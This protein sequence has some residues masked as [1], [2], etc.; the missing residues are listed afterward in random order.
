MVEDPP[1][2]PVTTP[3]FDPIVAIVGALLLHVPPAKS[4][5]V[6]VAVWH[7]VVFPVIVGLGCGVTVRVNDAGV[8]HTVV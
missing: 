7:T 2:D 8:P 4:L 5:N 6:V 1:S 3:V